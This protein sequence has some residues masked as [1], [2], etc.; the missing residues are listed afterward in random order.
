MGGQPRGGLMLRPGYHAVRQP[1][2][3]GLV[4][5]RV[6]EL[7]ARRQLIGQHA[8]LAA[9]AAEVLPVRAADLL[10]QPALK[11]RA[12]IAASAAKANEQDRLVQLHSPPLLPIW[13][14]SPLQP[15]AVTTATGPSA[16]AARAA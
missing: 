3:L 12:N 13:S 2:Q 1:V 15:L 14:C 5:V 6:D 11:L 9:M 16:P 8:V 7:D 4:H 10:A